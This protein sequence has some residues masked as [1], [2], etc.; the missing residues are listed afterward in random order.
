[1]RRFLVSLTLVG[2]A[3]TP[4][5]PSAVVGAAPSSR[6][7]EIG[8]ELYLNSDP[9]QLRDPIVANGDETL[10]FRLDFK[11]EMDVPSVGA[12]IRAHLPE[13]SRFRSL[14]DDHTVLFDVPPG[15][16]AF[17]VD[18]RGARTRPKPNIGIV[19]GVFWNVSRPTTTLALYRPTDIVA[20][21]AQPAVS[22]TFAFSADP[23]LIRLDPSR[24]AALVSIL[25]PQHL[26]F[27][28][29]PS[30]K[31]TALPSEL[32]KIG[33]NGAYMLWL[34]DGQFLTLGSH[35]TVISGPRGEDMRRLP[36]LLPGQS[37]WLSPN[38]KLVALESYPTDEA[39]IQ[40]LETGEL[41]SLGGEYR[42]CSAYWSAALSW[43]P[44]G[45]TVAIGYCVGDMQGPGRTALVDA[46][47]GRRMLALEGWSVMAW[48]A[49]GT[50][51]ARSW[52]DASGSYSRAA[53]P[54][55]AV[56]DAQG[57]VI[58]RI[59]CPM[60]YG[61]SPDGRWIVDG[62]LDAQRP[63]MRLVD[64]G[65]GRVYPLGLAGY[66]TWTSDGLIAVLARS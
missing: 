63:A 4:A 9:H 1:V 16:T 29:L 19:G 45:R 32:N 57:R 28:E 42:R 56:L 23:G 31:R 20:G 3:C 64:I 60:P 51:L 62:G 6:T 40:D 65:N 22:Y 30:G 13:A 7:F 37:G 18:P 54:A 47:T 33:A 66:P 38:G 49:N 50:M 58:R 10:T 14:N 53:D 11:T 39:G 41:R 8:A 17:A 12:A 48:L 21:A 55:L 59:E 5:Q 26:S 36:T 27:V 25:E 52:S 2:A 46:A 24:S 15:A 44:D 35:D 43:S 61:V 34:A